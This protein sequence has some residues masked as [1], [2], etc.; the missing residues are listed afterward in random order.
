MH[1]PVAKWIKLLLAVGLVAL[2]LWAIEVGIRIHSFSSMDETTDADVAIVL[3]AGTRNGRLSAVFRERIDHAID[4]YRRG[5]VHAVILTGGVGRGQQMADSEV[6]RSY[7]LEQGL[8]AEAVF[9]ETSSE[10]TVQNLEEAQ[11]LM[12]GNAWESCLI[13]SDPLHM[14]RAMLI[15]NDLGLQASPS[16]TTTSRISS[17]WANAWFL[18]RET[19]LVMQYSLFGG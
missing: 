17:P 3:G 2:L 10:D 4:L 12:T 15:A 5:V 14:Y 1:S 6:A 18:M 16:P 13:V 7:V 11:Q 9:I 8:P 19:I